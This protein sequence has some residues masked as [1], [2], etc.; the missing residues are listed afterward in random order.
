M[1]PRWSVRGNLWS[2]HGYTWFAVT[3]CGLRVA[4][5]G[6]SMDTCDVRITTYSQSAATCKDRKT[7]LEGMQSTQKMLHSLYGKESRCPGTA[8]SM[9]LPLI[10]NQTIEN[11]TPKKLYISKKLNCESSA[12]TLKVRG[13]PCQRPHVM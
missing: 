6:L 10:L 4:S 7:W 1:C 3:T 5:R 9:A 2:V 13:L 11:L 12:V 8:G